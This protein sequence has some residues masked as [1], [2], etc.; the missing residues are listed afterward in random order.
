LNR[1]ELKQLP[2]HSWNCITI[3]SGRRDIDLVIKNEKHM[4]ELQKFLIYS[5]NTL[6]GIR[7]SAG[8]LLQEMTESEITKLKS[9]T[10]Q[11]VLS[12]AQVH[13]INQINEA[14]VF[15]EICKKYKILTIRAKIS[16]MALAKGM[17]I[18]E[19]FLLSIWQVYNEYLFSGVLPIDP[20]LVEIDEIYKSII[21]GEKNI[22]MIA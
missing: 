19:T 20:K 14:K 16:F 15:G 1:E 9:I 17:T 2:F 6:N 5:L 4:V 7:N 12:A 18:Q 13:K 22:K 10:K 21:S 3:K 8:P 11:V